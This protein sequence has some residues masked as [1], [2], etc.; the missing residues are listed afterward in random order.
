MCYGLNEWANA[1]GWVPPFDGR[2]MPEQRIPVFRGSCTRGW[3]AGT[4]RLPYLPGWDTHHPTAEQY[5]GRLG[6][7]V[8]GAIAAARV[9]PRA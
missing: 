6:A 8:P 3:D 5:Y 9:P 7:V 4:G 1:S 2:R